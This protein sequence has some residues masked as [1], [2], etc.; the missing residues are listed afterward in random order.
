MNTDVFVPPSIVTVGA[1]PEGYVVDFLTEKQVKD[2]PE[3]YVRQNIEKALVRQYRY[4]RTFCRPEFSI[5]MGSKKPRVD[6]VVF[7]TGAIY[8][9]E[10]AQILVETK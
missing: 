10:H 3:E 9:Q 2:T 7:P 8:A 6:I 5:K 4:D 1:V